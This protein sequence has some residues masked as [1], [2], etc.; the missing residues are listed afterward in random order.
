MNRFMTA[1]LGAD[2]PGTA[3]IVGRGAH[4]IVFTFAKRL[5]DR[6]DRR[7]I[8]HVESHRRDVGQPGDAIFERPMDAG[9]RCARAREHFVPGAKLS[10]SALHGDAQFFA[11]GHRPTP[12]GVLRHQCRQFIRQRE[13]RCFDRFRP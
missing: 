8:E 4:G 13:L 11:I 7:Q 5:A 10:P 1:L 3:D 6:M 2:R 12:V 9:S